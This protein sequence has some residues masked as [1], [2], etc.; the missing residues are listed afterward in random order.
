MRANK[1][2]ALS[3]RSW[4]RPLAQRGTRWIA[5][6]FGDQIG[7]VYVVGYPKSGTTWISQMVASC[8][9]LPFVK[10]FP[11]LP[12]T[13]ACVL[14]HHWMYDPAWGRSIYVVRDG[15]DVVVSMYMNVM[16]NF[17]HRNEAFETADTPAIV[18]TVGTRIGRFS[19][20]T[21]RLH[22]LFGRNFD[23]WDVEGNLPKF[24]EAELTRPF[25]WAAGGTWQ[26][27]IRSW[28]AAGGR[29]A[30]VK[31]EDMLAHPARELT[32]A[33]ET[34][35]P[36]AVESRDVPHA[37]E[38]Y[39]FRRQSGR[40]RGDEDRTSFMRKGVAGDWRH[41]FSHAAAQAFDARAGDELISL[42]YETSHAWV[43]DVPTRL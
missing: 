40:E 29:T 10:P 23:P 30:V 41:L 24:I 22:R 12:I 43:D 15:R 38:K 14:H 16:K 36:G 5:R 20:P 13:F 18:R 27:H 26:D 34:L 33:L 3:L 31:Y 39:S 6:H 28:T 8:L 4:M 19:G 17:V 42:G 9:D 37:A 25:M 32:R 21:H 11:C 1:Y 2:F 7:F 35:A